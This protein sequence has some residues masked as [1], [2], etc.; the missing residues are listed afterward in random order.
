ME[1]KLAVKRQD[2]KTIERIWLLQG[3]G[4]ELADKKITILVR[5]GLFWYSLYFQSMVFCL[6]NFD[7]DGDFFFHY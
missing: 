4:T 5:K 6:V 7:T 1:V 3:I 2:L